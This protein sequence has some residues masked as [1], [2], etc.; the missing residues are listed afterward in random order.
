MLCILCALVT[1]FST[2]LRYFYTQVHARIYMSSILIPLMVYLLIFDS[3]EG[4]NECA[5]VPAYHRKKGFRRVTSSV[6]KLMCSIGTHIVNHAE[7]IK[8]RAR[9]DNIQKRHKIGV[10]NKCRITLAV[11]AAMAFQVQCTHWETKA[12]FDLDSFEIGIDNRYSGYIS[13]NPK[14]FIGQLRDCNRTIKGFMGTK[15][16]NIKIGILV[17]RW[18]DDKGRMHKFYIPDSY[19]VPNCNVRLLS[20]QHWAKTMKDNK[21]AEGTGCTTTSK[22]VQL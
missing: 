14:D 19:F 10:K 20:P 15:T 22:S 8:I 9:S 13:G 2:Y 11:L 5:Y 16:T 6:T 7:S 18:Q 12:A 4:V 3:S 1:I 17:W 21:P